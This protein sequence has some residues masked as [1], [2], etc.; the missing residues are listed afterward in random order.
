MSGSGGSEGFDAVVVGSGP[1]G[2]A[3]A[4]TLSAAGL[5]VLVVEGAQALGGG[6]RTEELTLPGF[7]HDVC[8]AAHPMAL[9]SSFFR[10]FDLA[11]HG[12]RMVHAEVF[13]AHP[14]DGGRAGVATRSV[15]ETASRLGGDR[16]AYERLYEPLVRNSEQIVGWVMSAE[17]RPPAH[18]F[19]MASYGM[20][21]LR[22]AQALAARFHGEEARALLAGI[23]AHAM[24][25]LDR[26]PTGAVGLL[27]GS[28]GHAVGWPFVEGGSGRLAEAMAAAVRSAGGEVR[29]G[30]WVTSLA[31]LPP[32]RAVLLDLSPR[33]VLEVAGDRLPS[34]YR[35]ALGRYRYGPG[36]FKMDFALSGAVPWSNPE[37]RR[38]GTVHLGGTFEEVALS[39]REVAAGRHPRSPYVLV[40][41][42]GSA[43]PSRAPVGCETL[44]VY[45][46]VPA[47]S[48]VD[49]SQRIESQ[50]ERFAPGFRDLIL[51]KATRTARQQEA[52]DPNCVGGDIAAG[53]QT[54]RQTLLRPALRWDPYRMPSPGLYL[55]S[56]A[57][58]PGPG[59]HGLC[60]AL[61]ARSALR[62]SFGL[63]R[64]PDLGPS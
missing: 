48:E 22:S 34:R 42:P 24:Q 19:A 8:S 47:G 25:P 15:A 50:I 12:V 29:S 17:R 5:R 18:P 31:E 2:L 36:V 46:H 53:A 64:A 30:L 21:A 39:E 6:C 28:L 51:A 49:M 57:T 54:L 59:V 20:G 3:A 7:R 44:W 10:D 60:G 13:L 26:L 38:A 16:A 1:N 41:Q 37:C 61:A 4:V 27:L 23:A 35:A 45:C 33:Q 63:S 32:A 55:C 52:H 14:L 43:D 58:T 40:T 62:H 11:A 9:A 56:S